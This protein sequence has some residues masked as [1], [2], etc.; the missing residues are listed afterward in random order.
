M[1]L[2]YFASLFPAVQVIAS[3]DYTREQI[4]AKEPADIQPN[5]YIDYFFVSRTH[6]RQ[7]IGTL[8]MNHIHE[9]AKLLGIGKL[10]SNESKTAELFFVLH[11]S[12]VAERESPI[13][14]RL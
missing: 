1:K 6:P 3:R 13:H 8:L 4:E 5:G 7:R 12:H 10:T 14:R 9:E 2:R 11:G